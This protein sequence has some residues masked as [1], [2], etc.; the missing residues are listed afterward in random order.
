MVRNSVLGPNA[1][2]EAGAQVE[3]ST[4]VDTI[5][6]SGSTVMGSTLRDSLV[7]SESRVTRYRGRLSIGDHSEV[8]GEE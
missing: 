4:V 2:V 6:G 7:G 5:L 8:E 1:T 3:D